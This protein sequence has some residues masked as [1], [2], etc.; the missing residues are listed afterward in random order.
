M[1]TY[2]RPRYRLGIE[3][4]GREY[5]FT[6]IPEFRTED[7]ARAHLRA[8]ARELGRGA[9]VFRTREAWAGGV[10]YGT[11]DSGPLPEPQQTQREVLRAE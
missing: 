5:V 11:H 10:H 9:Y 3:I 7:A 8:H 4:G 2:R 1:T 6:G